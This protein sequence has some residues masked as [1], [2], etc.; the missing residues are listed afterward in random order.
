MTLP[1]PVR[2]RGLFG[3]D[4]TLGYYASRN[5]LSLHPG[6]RLNDQPAGEESCRDGIQGKL[7]LGRATVHP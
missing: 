3:E 6:P 2:G 1:P 4:Q 7:Q 5:S